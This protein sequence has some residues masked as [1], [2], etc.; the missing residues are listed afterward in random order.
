MTDS[1]SETPKRPIQTSVWSWT[2]YGGSFLN[3]SNR[4]NKVI[5]STTL[6]QS[7]HTIK[8]STVEEHTKANLQVLIDQIYD[9][10]LTL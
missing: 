7:L 2:E 5:N 6:L 1:T 10:R 3:P 8:D 9:A 4:T